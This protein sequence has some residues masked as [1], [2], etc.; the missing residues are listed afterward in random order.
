[1]KDKTSTYS[2]GNSCPSVHQYY[3]AWIFAILFAAYAYF[4]Q[5]G[6]WNQNSRFD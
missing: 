3:G 1:M 6:G 4:H 2:S 5:G